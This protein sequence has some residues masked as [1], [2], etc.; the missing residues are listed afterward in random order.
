[1]LLVSFDPLRTL[2][3]PGVHNL[4]A[5]D[6]LRQQNLIR[7][8]DWVLF[9]EYWLVNALTY[10]WKKR[11]FPSVAAHH[12][13]HDKVEMTRAF[14]AVCPE[15]VPTTRILP[16][17][18]RNAELVASDWGFPFVAKE[19]RSSMGNGVHLI[20]DPADWRRYVCAHEILYVQEYLP[21]RR[22][23]RVVVI[24]TRVVAAYW[25]EAAEGNFLNNV[26]KGGTVSFDGIPASSIALVER[27]ARKLGIDHAG[28]DVAELGGHPYLLE[29]NVRFGTSALVERGIRLAPHILAYLQSHPTAQATEM[30]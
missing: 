9:P 4:K 29:F 28:F 27:V 13:G 12:L 18:P 30:T 11:I 20:G 23:L 21:I 16:N 22:D 24:G 25:R 6:W 5:E 1:M 10:A 15:N 17:T 3:I 7:S 14:E 19:V 26:A 2:E 8:A